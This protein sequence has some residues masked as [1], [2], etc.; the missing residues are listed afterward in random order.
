MNLLLARFSP[1]DE[2]RVL[3]EGQTHGIFGSLLIGRHYR[4]NR[5]L[6]A[7][8]SIAA[9]LAGGFAEPAQRSCRHTSVGC[10]GSSLL[11]NASGMR[12]GREWASWP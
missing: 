1:E 12:S 2:H 8:S 5:W 4:C 6:S 3:L 10:A 9:A 11:L 7:L